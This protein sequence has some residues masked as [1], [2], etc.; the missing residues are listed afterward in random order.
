MSFLG[1]VCSGK[2]G[3]VLLLLLMGGPFLRERIQ[4]SLRDPAFDFRSSIPPGELLNFRLNACYVS[5]TGYTQSCNT[6]LWSLT[7]VPYRITKPVANISVDIP[8]KPD[9]ARNRSSVVLSLEISQA[10]CDPK[11]P[12][13]WRAAIYNEPIHWKLPSSHQLHN[14]LRGPTAPPS[15]SPTPFP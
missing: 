11:A 13:C 3:I 7:D 6:Q 14:L 2:F 9:V 12:S 1:F 5:H 8:I 15:A 10:H 4:W